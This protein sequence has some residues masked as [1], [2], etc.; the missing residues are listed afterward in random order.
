MNHITNEEVDRRVKRQNAHHP[1]G[2]CWILPHKNLKMWPIDTG[3]PCCDVDS[4]IWVCE[5]CGRIVRVLHDV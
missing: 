2:W 5:R 1:R 4:L 3:G